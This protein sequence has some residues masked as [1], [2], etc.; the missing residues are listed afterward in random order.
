MLRFA[1]FFILMTTQALAHTEC[2]FDS[3]FEDGTYGFIKGNQSITL[4]KPYS[5]FTELEKNG[6][7]LLLN[8]EVI[9]RLKEFFPRGV[10]QVGQELSSY[11]C[12]VW[13]TGG[14]G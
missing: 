1:L 5:K 13:R 7:N 6:D 8:G 3:N 11:K 4:L 14:R 10:I 9:G 12:T 2:H